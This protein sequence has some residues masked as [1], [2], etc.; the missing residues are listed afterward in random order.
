MCGSGRTQLRCAQGLTLATRRVLHRRADR[1]APAPPSPARAT[2]SSAASSATSNEAKTELLGV[3]ADADRPRMARSAR[4]VARGHGRRRA[5]R[6]RVPQ[7]AVAVT[8]IAGPGGGTPSKPVGTVWLAW[9]ARRRRLV[10]TEMLQLA[11]RSPRDPR[12]DRRRAMRSKRLLELASGSLDGDPA[13]GEFRRRA[14]WAP[15]RPALER[16]AARRALS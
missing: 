14:S 2:G 5:G 10:E 1:R 6:I 11:R 3:P 4:E 7:L 13:A 16:R 12:A 8:G 15:W 9:C